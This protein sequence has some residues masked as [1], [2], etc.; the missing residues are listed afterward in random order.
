MAR[1]RRTASKSELGASPCFWAMRRAMRSWR[2]V[3]P[4]LR[5]ASMSLDAP[6]SEAL[7][8][9]PARVSVSVS[10]SYAAEAGSD[11]YE[12]LEPEDCG[13]GYC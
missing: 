12:E 10:G 6:I 2:P 1:S 5:M 8:T 3:R 7:E 13:P 11:V 4:S 9:M